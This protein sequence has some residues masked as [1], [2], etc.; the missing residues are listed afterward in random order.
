M[1]VGAASAGKSVWICSYTTR[2]G[3]S[4]G[5]SSTPELTRVIRHAGID[6]RISN[7]VTLRNASHACRWTFV[8]HRANQPSSDGVWSN[9]P[10]NRRN[11]GIR[12]SIPAPATCLVDSTSSAGTKVVATTTAITTTLT[13]PAP[14]DWMIVM[15]MNSSPATAIATVTPL[16]I[17]VRPAVA[18]VIAIARSRTS[19]GTSRCAPGTLRSCRSC[20]CSR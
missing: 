1:I 12:D 14:T 6:S 20:I 11:P 16:N 4:G 9:A 2:V 18:I 10:A 17:T 15:S 7:A 19:R 3:L 13:A 5:S 8:A